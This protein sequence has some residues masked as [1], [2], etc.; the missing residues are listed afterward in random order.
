M[1]KKINANANNEEIIFASR[2]DF[3]GQKHKL[4]ICLCKWPFEK[5]GGFFSNENDKMA[6]RFG[7]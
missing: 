1:R 5:C 4:L 3:S 7:L 6:L 2:E